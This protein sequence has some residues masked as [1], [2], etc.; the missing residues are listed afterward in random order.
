MG[1]HLKNEF[2][3][4][5]ND[6][7]NDNE[8]NAKDNAHDLVNKYHYGNNEGNKS[9][10]VKI[11]TPTNN[12]EIKDKIN[13]QTKIINEYNLKKVKLDSEIAAI[14]HELS[15]LEKKKKEK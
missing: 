2:N 3:Y 11:D 5:D 13:A 14:E 8:F 7:K 9:R 15:E 10:F 6:N 4:G 1:K 12:S